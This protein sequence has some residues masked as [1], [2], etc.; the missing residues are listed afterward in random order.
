MRDNCKRNLAQRSLC[1]LR[2]YKLVQ[3]Q[4][5]FLS[6]SQ[7]YC[8]APR[9]ERGIVY[10]LLDE[11]LEPLMLLDKFLEE[12]SPILTDNF[13]ITRHEACLTN[14]L[15]QIKTNNNRYALRINSAHA[16]RLGINR[17]RELTILEHIHDQNWSLQPVAK[18]L[19]FLLTP[20]VETK[21]FD[22][23]NQIN[24]L[25][26]LIRAV[27]NVNT[28]LLDVPHLNINE[29][30]EHLLKH[31]K[32]LDHAFL[33]CLD[34]YRNA[35]QFPTITTL[36][37]HDWHSGNLLQTDTQLYLNDWEYAALGDPLVDIVCALQGFDIKEE[38]T[39]I[40]LSQLNIEAEATFPIQPLVAAMS[41][42]W[43]QVRFPD[44]AQEANIQSFLQRWGSSR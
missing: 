28:T 30:I 13:S 19:E 38:L 36:C 44:Q 3:V 10:R 18:S 9:Q 24:E 37:H 16:E 22:I 40:L 8:L 31:C 39:A 32:Q 27:H 43:Y 17:I 7:Y 14:A 15:Y 25:S 33:T 1:S 41:I 21:R 34:T 29:Q 35:Y 11:N 5:V 26:L 20:W 42:L 6:D 2:Q 23:S 12:L 4:R